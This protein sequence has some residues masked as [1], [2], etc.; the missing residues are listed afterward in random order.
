MGGEAPPPPGQL[1]GFLGAVTMI[2]TTHV[3]KC[4]GIGIHSFSIGLAWVAIVYYGVS[5]SH[6]ADAAVA[7]AVAGPKARVV[8]EGGL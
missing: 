4:Q 3:V 6:R 2:L 7:N 8:P 5:G 1:L